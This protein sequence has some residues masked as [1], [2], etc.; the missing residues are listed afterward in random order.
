MKP[1]PSYGSFFLIPPSLYTTGRL[2]GKF[3]FRIVVPGRNW[4]GSPGFSVDEVIQY[5]EKIFGY[6]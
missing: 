6:G 3:L 5:R 4:A 1:V 2:L